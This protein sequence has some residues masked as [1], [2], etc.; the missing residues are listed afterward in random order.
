[1]NKNQ[2]EEAVTKHKKFYYFDVLEEYFAY[3]AAHLI[4]TT[5]I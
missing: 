4:S 5:S 3:S 1:M 2:H